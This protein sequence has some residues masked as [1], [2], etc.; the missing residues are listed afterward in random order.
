[1]PN[2][3]EDLKKRKDGLD[4]LADI[5]RYAREG[6]ESIDPDDFN[7][8]KWYG[9]YEQK[10][11][12]GGHFM[13]RIKV[14]GG[15][16]TAAQMREVGRLANQYARGFGDITTRQAFQL[17][18]LR[19]EDVPDIFSRLERVGLTTVGACGDI[20]RN[21][22]NCPVAGCDRQEIFDTQP[23]VLR[24]SRHFLGNR[25]YSNLPRKYK[26]SIS[27]CAV[28]CTFPQI[29]CVAFV[30][31][32]H[33][34]QGVEEEGYNIYIGG[35]LSTAPHFAKP[36][37]IF[38][39]REQVLDYAVA[40]TE[41]YRDHGGRD[42]RTRARLKF[43]MDDWG[44]EKFREEIAARVPFE[45]YPAS[46]HPLRDAHHDH[47][48]IHPQKQDGK[49]YIGVTVKIGRIT[50]DQMLGAADI[51]ERYGSGRLANTISQNFIVFDIPE[52]R[53]EEAAGELRALG[54]DIGETTV[55]SDCV[56][57]TG[58]EFCNLAVTETKGL[59]SEVISYLEQNVRWDRR[60]RV[61]MTGCPNN[62]GQQVISDIGLQGAS[63]RIEGQEVE[64][65]DFHVGG[66][67]GEDASFVRKI[68]R[69]IAA[70]DVKLGVANI[71]RAYQ[72]GRSNGESFRDW[73][74]RHS[75]E[76]LAQML[77]VVDVKVKYGAQA[78][79]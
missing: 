23:D 78:E 10:P 73:T 15:H 19:I 63:T 21:I 43:L 69:R 61:H 79:S 36:V 9:L 13:L 3:I 16:Y 5:Y 77:G 72:Q 31:V 7:L 52:E 67:L 44:P 37:N 14:H 47:L 54:F 30:G 55:K 58:K 32:P 65:Y 1:M 46:G 56:V 45:P 59:M 39:T 74:R 8:F 29:N 33:G 48:G 70:E 17:H 68:A 20:M 40:I 76:E 51:A 75:D 71:V 60:I 35:G 66:G 27:A 64:C 62:C 57:C 4:V 25:D 18:W 50:G 24:V 2:P 38:A 12:G 41:I 22:T 11:R 49:C 26:V 6:Y 42:R 28:N 34:P 53:V